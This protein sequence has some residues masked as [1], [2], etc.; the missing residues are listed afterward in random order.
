MSLPGSRNPKL[1]RY[2]QQYLNEEDTA[3]FIKAVSQDYTVG[4][5]SRL[6]AHN[7]RNVRRAAVLALTFL[8]DYG[9]NAVLGRALHD[10][11][12]GVRVIAENGIR[13]LWQRDGSE[14]QRQRLRIIIRRNTAR[15]YEQAVEIADALIDEAPWF[16][17]AWNQRAIAYFNLNRFA[18]S[19]GDCHQALELNAYHYAAAVGMAHCY[20]EL[21]DAFAALDN[22]RRALRLNPGL[23]GVRA[24]VEYLQRSLEEK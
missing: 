18:E 17:E 11:D 14:S 6:S 8:A 24:Q 16:A 9:E 13:E 3:A 20:L 12:R 1:N 5:L 10:D 7:D 2:Y 19:A 22:F 15:H 23:E 4:T 21:N